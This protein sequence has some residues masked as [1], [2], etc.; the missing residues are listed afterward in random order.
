MTQEYVS[1]EVNE[2][3]HIICK[4]QTGSRDKYLSIASCRSR[5]QAQTLVNILNKEDVSMG[6]VREFHEAFNLPI[7]KKSITHASDGELQ[8]LDAIALALKTYAKNLHTDNKEYRSLLIIRVQLM[9][10]ELGEVI[11]AIVEGNVSNVLHELADLRYTVDGTADSLGF[12]NI[13]FEAVKLIHAAN[14]SKLDKDGK[15]IIDES[16]R[17]VKSPQFKKAD[18]SVLL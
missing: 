4:R 6:L 12:G 13:F 3:N 14:M 1:L 18:V 11:S 5:Y 15:P 17:V 2:K 16:G 8:V 10:E 9:V 7:E